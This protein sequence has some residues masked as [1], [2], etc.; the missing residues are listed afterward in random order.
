MSILYLFVFASDYNSYNIV[1][2]SNVALFFKSL[3]FF[4]LN[5]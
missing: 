3:L 1:D 2:Y 5:N 4:L